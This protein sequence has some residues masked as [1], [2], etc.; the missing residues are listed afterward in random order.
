MDM[1]SC[2]RAVGL[3]DISTSAMDTS[4]WIKKKL[5]KNTKLFLIK[6]AIIMLIH[7]CKRG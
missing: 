5:F 2:N 6:Y 7:F 1:S 3:N 4:T